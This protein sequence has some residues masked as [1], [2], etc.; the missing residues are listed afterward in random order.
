M[1][2]DSMAHGQVFLAQAG[3]DDSDEVFFPGSFD[4]DGHTLVRCQ[5]FSGRDITKEHTPDRAQGTKLICHVAD[6]VFKVPVKGA[7][8]YILIPHGMEGVSGAGVIIASVGGGKE[9]NKNITAGDL[10]IAPP[11]GGE[12]AVVI[13]AD[14]SIT[15]HT[16]DNNDNN[17]NSTFIR[18]SPTAIQFVAPWGK[19]IFDASGVHWTTKS[20]ARLDMGGISVPGLPGAIASSFDSYVKIQAA[21]VKVAGGS[22]FLGQGTY[23][24]PVV[25]TLPTDPTNFLPLGIKILAPTLLPQPN[26]VGS[27]SVWV[28]AMA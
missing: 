5:L 8:V 24:Q 17:G 20:G 4:D 28:S 10:I 1:M 7:R 15:L 18:V 16:T 13:K 21:T 11:G 6:G 25:S 23:Y 22:V 19:M 27:P 9:V 12:A 26:L 14:G 3:W 2:H